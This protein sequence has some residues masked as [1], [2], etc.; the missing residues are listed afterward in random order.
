MFH[1]QQ[2]K[3]RVLGGETGNWH[4]E[5]NATVGYS[6]PGKVTFGTACNIIVEK[7]FAENRIRYA[8]RG[9]YACLV[10]RVGSTALR[11]IA[12]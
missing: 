3:P 2:T 5:F 11:G 7:I 12:V 10:Q 4:R 9:D 8:Q 6:N 1:G